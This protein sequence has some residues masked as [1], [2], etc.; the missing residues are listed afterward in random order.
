MKRDVRQ[1]ISDILESVLNGNSI[2]YSAALELSRVRANPDL[3]AAAGR[4]REHQR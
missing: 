4:V 3:L 2:D 1:R